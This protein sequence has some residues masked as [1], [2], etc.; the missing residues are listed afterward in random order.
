[1]PIYEYEHDA[2][3]GAE[4]Q[5]RFEILQRLDEQ[6]LAECPTC[7]RPCHR[8]LSAFATGRSTKTGLPG[9]VDLSPGNLER[10]GF[11][12]YRRAGGGRYEKTCG[13]GPA[14]INRD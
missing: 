6:A 5:A 9:K 7:G 2:E 4:C 3:F 12:Q 1:M 13:E 8:V 11:T 10:L 14:T